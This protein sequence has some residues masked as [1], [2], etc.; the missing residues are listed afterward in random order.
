LIEVASRH[1]TSRPA[2]FSGRPWLR[3]GGGKGAGEFD[4]AT[5]AKGALHGLH[6]L[7][8]MRRM[9]LPL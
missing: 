4:R 5:L 6:D 3:L 2:G 7:D 9:R 1:I 8:D